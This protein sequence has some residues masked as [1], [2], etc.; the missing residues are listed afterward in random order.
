LHPTRGSF[1]AL[2]SLFDAKELTVDTSTVPFYPPPGRLGNFPN[3]FAA[4]GNA[5]KVSRIRKLDSTTSRHY[6]PAIDCPDYPLL[7]PLPTTHY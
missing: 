5:I 6:A 2:L 7:T 4:M 3:P 1:Y